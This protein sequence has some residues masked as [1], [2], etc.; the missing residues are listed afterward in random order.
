[1]SG[2]FFIGLHL[3]SHLLLVYLFG[4]PSL[5]ENLLAWLAGWGW[6]K[7]PRSS[8]HDSFMCYEKRKKSERQYLKALMIRSI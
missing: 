5:L 2:K 4:G 6:G 8:D 1:M 7:G 3:Y